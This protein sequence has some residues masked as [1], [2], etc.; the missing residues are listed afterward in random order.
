MTPYLTI[1]QNVRDQLAVVG[2]RLEDTELVR[3]ALN[4]FTRE[5]AMFVQ[6]IT[7]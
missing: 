3:I 5:W 1:I 2:K 7:G 6:R 4:G